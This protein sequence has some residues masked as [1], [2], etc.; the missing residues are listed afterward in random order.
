VKYF[1]FVLLIIS[2]SSFATN[3]S[4][5]VSEFIV[6]QNIPSKSGLVSDTISA[7]LVESYKLDND[8]YI[9]HWLYQVANYWQ[10]RVYLIESSS[11]KVNVLDKLFIDGDIKNTLYDKNVLNIMMLTYGKTT[12]RC[13]PNIEKHLNY[14]VH[15]S[16]FILE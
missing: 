4:R 1:I 3:Q 13:C 14:K 12:P 6:S 15:K 2:S 16:K 11:S 10:H 9:V 5:I 8:Q 7:K